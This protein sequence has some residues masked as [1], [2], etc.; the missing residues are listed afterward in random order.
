LGAAE[1]RYVLQSPGLVENCLG[2]YVPL[3]EFNLS[4]QSSFFW[5]KQ[6]CRPLAR[7]WNWGVRRVH[8][9]RKDPNR[10]QLTSQAI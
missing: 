8:D 6:I 1:P 3:L 2:L 9:I 5:L 10:N 4:P 7:H